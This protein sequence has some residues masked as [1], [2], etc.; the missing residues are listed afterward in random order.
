MFSI[1]PVFGVLFSGVF[2]SKIIFK[3]TFIDLL[4]YLRFVVAAERSVPMFTC[5]CTPVYNCLPECMGCLY[6]GE[7]IT[8]ATISLAVTKLPHGFRKGT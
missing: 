4:Y 6:F 7:F 3:Q 8:V 2:T 1:F 5:W